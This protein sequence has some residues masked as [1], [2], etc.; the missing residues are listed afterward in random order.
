MIEMIQNDSIDEMVLAP[1]YLIR[2]AWGIQEF[3]D[4]QGLAQFNL[5]QDR[6]LLG[7]SSK[8]ESK[9]EWHITDSNIQAEFDR[10]DHS[11]VSFY[12]VL[13]WLRIEIN[14]YNSSQDYESGKLLSL[15]TKP[16]PVQPK[17]DD[18]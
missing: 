4:L 14:L 16:V 12:F 9:A 15:I 17:S 8:N 3:K 6:I 7:G 11:R 5:S 2:E 10:G 1:S 13:R 18:L